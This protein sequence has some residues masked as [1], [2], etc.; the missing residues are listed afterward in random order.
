MKTEFTAQEKT[1][2]LKRFILEKVPATKICAEN[3]ISSGRLKRWQE[4]LFN[5]GAQA[6]QYAERARTKPPRTR[7]HRFLGRLLG[8]LLTPLNIDV[9]TELPVMT[10][11]PEADIVIIRRKGKRWLRKQRSVLPDGVRDVDSPTIILEF[12]YSESVN[13]KALSQAFNYDSL[14]K[15]S[16]ALK[17]GMV[18]TFLISSKTPSKKVLEESGY[19][20]TDKPGVYSTD[21]YLLNVIDLIDLNELS[22]EPHNAFIKCFASRKKQ[23]KAAFKTLTRMGLELF[24]NQVQWILQGLA[25]LWFN[26]KG[27][28]KMEL[29]DIEMTPEG[30]MEF[31]KI[32]G[33]GFLKNLPIE[34]RLEG[35]PVDV[36]KAYLD[37]LNKKNKESV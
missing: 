22:D 9:F 34:K 19:L 5:N 26:P 21:A 30:L 7:W 13:E 20:E 4:D 32:W 10:F 25:Q 15:S 24:S 18:R 27:A 37:K 8:E 36:L 2:I 12:K 6:L 3:H 28:G 33:D 16:H 35:I 29:T 14:Y 11:P 23:K 17:P 1:A 31:G